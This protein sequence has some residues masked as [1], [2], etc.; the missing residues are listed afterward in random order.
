M[1][2]TDGSFKKQSRKG[3][4][5]STQDDAY[6][7]AFGETDGI[8]LF[9]SLDIICERPKFIRNKFTSRPTFVPFEEKRA[10]IK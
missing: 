8:Y 5:K 3:V 10:E 9:L 1:L 6:G 2:V 4:R 7:E